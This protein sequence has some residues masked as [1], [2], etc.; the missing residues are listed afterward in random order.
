MLSA[1][2]VAVTVPVWSALPNA[3][4][5]FPTASSALVA[6]SVVV[7]VVAVVTLTVAAV[8]APVEPDGP[9]AGSL[10]A[11]VE[12]DTEVTV[13]D[14]MSPNPRTVPGRKPPPGCA[15]EGRSVGRLVRLPPGRPPKPPKPPR[16]Q[17]PLTGALMTTVVAVIAVGAVAGDAG[18]DDGADDVAAVAR[19]HMPAFT[20]ANDVVTVCVYWVAELTVTA[21][22][23]V[24]WFCTWT[25]EPLIAAMTPNAP[26]AFAPPNLAPAPPWVPPAALALGAAAAG[27]AAEPLLHPARSRAAAP[28]AAPATSA[29]RLLV[30]SDSVIK[31][32]GLCGWSGRHSLRSASMGASRAARLAG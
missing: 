29:R 15:P 4:I 18:A 19:T 24:L 2:R 32:L 30:V 6:D 21:V 12:P 7:Y 25:V 17:L 26:G 22:C 14:T 3:V 8:A 5:H 10:T 20:A 13:P 31:V 27:A 11:I 23:P 9:R 16:P 1:T 28:A